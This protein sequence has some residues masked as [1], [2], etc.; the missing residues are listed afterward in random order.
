MHSGLG[1][2]YSCGRTPSC[3]RGMR[4][5]RVWVNSDMDAAAEFGTN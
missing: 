4:H 1:A 3:S 5:Q 2:V